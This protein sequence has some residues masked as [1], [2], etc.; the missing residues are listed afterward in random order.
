M[1][2]PDR[3][4]DIPTTLPRFR[5]QLAQLSHSQAGLPPDTHKRYKRGLV[6]TTF[7]NLLRRRP[8]L[9]RALCADLVDDH[10]DAA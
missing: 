1:S 3:T 2:E 6:P 7:I 9:A 4:Q 8:D 10:R 5:A